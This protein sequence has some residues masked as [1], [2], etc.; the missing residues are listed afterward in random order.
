MAIGIRTKLFLTLLAT[1]VCVVVSMFV[2]MRWSLDRGFI[3]YVNQV[4]QERL[5]SLAAS[6]E[7]A[8][9]AEGSWG[10]ITENPRRW[11]QLVRQALPE[12]AREARPPEE[13]HGPRE[14]REPPRP[15]P[16]PHPRMGQP[17]EQR[18]LLLDGDRAE[19]F[20][21]ADP[22][23][24]VELRPLMQDGTVIGF[25]ALKPRKALSDSHQVRFVR[26]QQQAFALIALVI[27]ALA[28]LLSIP[29]ARRLVRRVRALAAA[30]HRL[31][32]GV[33]E[34]RIE[35]GASDELGLLARDFN[36][37]AQALEEAEQTRRQWVADISHEL[38]TPLAI[39][40][41]EIEALQDGV[42]EPTPQAIDS[43]HEEVLRLARLVNDLY[44]L[45][46]SDVGA[47]TY[48]KADVDL[49]ALL[50]ESLALY[51]PDLAAREI[52]LEVCIPEKERGMVHADA[53]RLHQLFGNLLE[54]SLKYTDPGGK[55]CV[56]LEV[57]KERVR[58]ALSDS[59]PGV[60]EEDLPK[61][62]DRLYRVENSRNRALGGAGLGLALCRNIVEAH[63]GVIEAHPSSLGGLSITVELPL[64][65]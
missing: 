44:E 11:R 47:L 57:G 6:L 36:G 31:T 16:P 30:T 18:L 4:E 59:A 60:P 50:R 26:E 49:G 19:L 65:R 14:S 24:P 22:S 37:L 32:A 1:A 35:T 39:L 29:L 38:R 10:F 43:L 58:V 64:T 54:N 45:S 56:K 62:F 34:T 51:A 53:G 13:G 20:G 9:G 3:R 46:L 12:E 41:G 7:D 40:R 25:L 27:I 17:F 8:Y 15:A 2:I 28:A 33:Y 23:G 21:H 63:G 5:E 61:L 48:R 42:R 52:A 55:L